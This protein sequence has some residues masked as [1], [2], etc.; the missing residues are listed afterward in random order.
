MKEVFPFFRRFVVHTLLKHLSH[1][2][3]KLRGIDCMEKCEVA[4]KKCKIEHLDMEVQSLC[5]ESIVRNERE[6]T[7]AVMHRAEKQQF[8]PLWQ[9]TLG[10][11]HIAWLG[12]IV[13][14]FGIS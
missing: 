10:A 4:A 1:C 7:A 12:R 13:I 2:Q 5:S 11:R 3:M 9:K 14:L 6:F 8:V